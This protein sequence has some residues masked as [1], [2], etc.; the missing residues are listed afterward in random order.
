ML[1]VIIPVH[2][3]QKYLRRC[4]NSIVNQTYRD[5]E[6][7]LVENNSTDSSANICEEYKILD[8]RV[9]VIYENKVGAAAARNCGMHYAKGEYITFVDSDDYLEENAYECIMYKVE[10]TK[11][12]LV[13][14]SFTFVD[15]NEN[16]INWYTPNLSRYK[17]KKYFSG[18]DIASIYLT[19]RDI[20]GFGWNKVFRKSIFVDNNI[21]FDENK[22]AYEDMSI[23]FDAICCCKKAALLPKSLYFYRQVSNSLTHETY[24]KKNIEYH[25]SVNSI[26][27]SAD[28]VGLKKQAEVFLLSRKIYTLYE[29]YKNHNQMDSGFRL[30]SN[31]L[32]QYMWLIVRYYKSEKIKM[33]FKLFVVI[34]AIS[35]CKV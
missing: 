3:S 2:N 6:I 14:Y 26:I 23:L 13:C 29:D 7:I 18:I 21:K 8:K 32:L 33:I 22:K 20:E 31:E 34:M 25:D 10:E 9:K 4:I 28:N 1:S 27:K 5:M 35:K 17:K 15:E 24:V 16:K 30:K 11:V 12:D 19:S